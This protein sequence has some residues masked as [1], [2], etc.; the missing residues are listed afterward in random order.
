MVTFDI[1]SLSML[2]NIQIQGIESKRW[3]WI[4]P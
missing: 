4:V 2:T 1:R 3:L